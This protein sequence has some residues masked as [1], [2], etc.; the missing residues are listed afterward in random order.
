MF[1]TETKVKNLSRVS[2]IP[3]EAT[4]CKAG[5]REYKIPGGYIL[6]WIQQIMSLS[7]WHNAHQVFDKYVEDQPSRQVHQV[8][9]KEKQ[10]DC[11]LNIDLPS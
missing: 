10:E 9:T 4:S 11:R 1:M 8:N 3:K 6:H 5:F 7:H 2:S